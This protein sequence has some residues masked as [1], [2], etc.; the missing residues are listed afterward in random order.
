VLALLMSGARVP[1][2]AKQ[3]FISPNTVRNHL[4]AIYRKVDVSS[5]SDLVEWVRSLGAP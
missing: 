4:K 2:I 3:L 5:Q 1:A